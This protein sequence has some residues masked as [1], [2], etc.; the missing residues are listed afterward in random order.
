[1]MKLYEVAQLARTHMKHQASLNKKEKITV[2]LR[3]CARLRLCGKQTRRI[4]IFLLLNFKS[5]NFIVSNSIY[6]FLKSNQH[7]V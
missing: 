5:R 6:K 1:M 7:E 3:P 2:H 4:S